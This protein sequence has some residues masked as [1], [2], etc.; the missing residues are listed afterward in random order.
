MHAVALKNALGMSPSKDFVTFSLLSDAHF[1]GVA[2]DSS[3][4]FDS[5]FGSP[6]QILSLVRAKEIAQALLAES[7]RK[8]K[9]PSRE[10]VEAHK[11]SEQVAND[12]QCAST[13]EP[14]TSDP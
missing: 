12:V 5:L 13:P 9:V 14:P 10:V 11:V 2:F 7:I 4:V 6:K 3:L 8:S 1:L